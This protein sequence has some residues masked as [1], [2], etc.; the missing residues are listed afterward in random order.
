M[1][2]SRH[3]AWVTFPFPPYNSPSTKR[4]SQ[5]ALEIL[6]RGWKLTVFTMPRDGYEDNGWDYM[7]LE[8]FERFPNFTRVSIM[9]LIR[10]WGMR[11]FNDRFHC[12]T[13]RIAE[14]GVG[15]FGYHVGIEWALQVIWKSYL[16]DLA[17]CD[18][19]LASSTPCESFY[20]ASKI[21]ERLNIPYVLD[22]RDLWTTNFFHNPDYYPEKLKQMER[23]LLAN[24]AAVTSVGFDMSQRLRDLEPS[25]NVITRTNGYIPIDDGCEAPLSQ[26]DDERIRIVYAGVFYPPENSLRPL[27]SAF[28]QMSESLRSRCQFIYVGEQSDQILELGR[29]FE[30]SDMVTVTGRLPGKEA[31]SYIKS[32]TLMVVSSLDRRMAG[33]HP[34]RGIISS[35]IYECM[36]L[37]KA[38][39][40]IAPEDADIRNIA[41]GCDFVYPFHGEQV[42]E[43]SKFLEGELPNLKKE[44][45]PYEKYSWSHLRAQY[46]DLLDRI[47]EGDPTACSQC[48]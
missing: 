5:I 26:S 21:A 24:A 12:I 2:K 22:Y 45:S 48:Q 47:V 6:E 10:Y 23:S 44:N 46:A 39:L 42:D 7:P 34:S 11:G 38:T 30:I 28:R 29:E 9:P 15:K 40:L 41:K 33:D 4:M 3:V 19:V 18:V 13:R 31:V 36:G 17:D 1:A 37:G 14:R 43:M 32:A 27:F 20:A 25:A 8:A 35:K 16:V